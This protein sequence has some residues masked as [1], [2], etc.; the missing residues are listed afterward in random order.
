MHE[1]LVQGL[2]NQP[3]IQKLPRPVVK[4]KEFTPVVQPAFSF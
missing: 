3:G 1:L 2:H 4:R